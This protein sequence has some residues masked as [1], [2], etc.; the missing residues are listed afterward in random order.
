MELDTLKTFFFKFEK[1]LNFTKVWR[2]KCAEQLQSGP[3]V[4]SLDF[5]LKDGNG[6]VVRLEQLMEFCFSKRLLQRDTL[7][8]VSVLTVKVHCNAMRKLSYVATYCFN[9]KVMLLFIGFAYKNSAVASK[10]RRPETF[11]EEIR[12]WVLAFGNFYEN[13]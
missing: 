8:F 4:I 3:L 2:K 1:F 11:S 10:T 12:T 9:L 13:W 5:F 6:R 7:R